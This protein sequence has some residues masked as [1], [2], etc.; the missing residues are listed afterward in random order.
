M[1]QLKMK[2]V[3]DNL[4]YLWH[5]TSQ[6]DPKMFYN[7]EEGFDIKYS[8]NGFWGRGLYFAEDASY[9]YSYSHAHKDNVKGMFLA[10]V[11]LGNC[12]EMESD[13]SIIE[14]PKG[15]DSVT[16]KTGENNMQQV[17]IVYANKKAYP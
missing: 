1:E 16:G 4:K 5:G 2:G 8:N 6:S 7:G 9:S 13:K 10:Y 17:Y 12:K 3:K 15:Y 14:P 11:N